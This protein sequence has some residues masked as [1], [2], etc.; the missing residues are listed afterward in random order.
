MFRLITPF[1]IALRLIEI[2][3]NLIDNKDAA[4]S[5]LQYCSSKIFH[6][7]NTGGAIAISN[8]SPNLIVVAA[9]QHSR[10]QCSKVDIGG[11]QVGMFGDWRK[12]M[13]WILV[14]EAR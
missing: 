12:V 4:L 1:A 6:S 2:E 11:G 10:K 8:N 9:S 7:S 3:N 5:Q 13:R 14:R